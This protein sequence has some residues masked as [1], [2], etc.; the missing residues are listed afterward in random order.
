MTQLFFKFTKEFFYLLKKRA[1]NMIGNKIHSR[2]HCQLLSH[3]VPIAIG[4]RRVPTFLADNL[5]ITPSP[6]LSITLHY[7]STSTTPVISYLMSI[8][9]VSRNRAANFNKCN[10]LFI[11]LTNTYK[12]LSKI[13]S[14][15][16]ISVV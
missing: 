11:L 12:I 3:P 16:P 9:I 14:I 5:S 2:F 4:S 8:N 1:T 7:L 13:F 6:L 10:V 15:R